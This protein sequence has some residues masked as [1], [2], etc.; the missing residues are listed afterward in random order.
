MQVY[1]AFYK[2]I[3][4][5]MTQIL[6]YIIVFVSIATSLGNINAKKEKSIFQETKVNIAFINDDKESEFIKGFEGY[7][8]R[9]CNI[10]KLSKEKESLQDALFYREVEYIIKVPKGF[11]E[12]FFSG[13]PV[14]I[15]T[16][17]V[18]ESSSEVYM[19]NM[20][21]KYLNTAKIYIN[22]IPNLS[23]EQ[24]VS[25]IDKD[26]SQKTEVKLNNFSEEVDKNKKIGFYYN[27]MAYSILGVLIL[28][29]CSVML[30]FNNRNL[31][32]RNLCTPVKLKNINFQLILGSLSFTVLAWLVM[33]IIS[34]FMYGSYMLTGKGLLLLLNSFIF[35]LASVS[36]GFLVGNIVKSKNTMS[37]ASNVIVLGTCFI[38]GVFVEQSLLSK[39]VLKLA[40]F[41]PNY[42]YVKANNGIVA[43]SGYSLESL[44]SIFLN[45]L[46]VMGFAVSILLV[47][48]VIIKQKRLSN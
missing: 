34:F 10:V 36:I 12:E 16:T 39:Q 44:S 48:L 21:N 5:N 43:L 20:V 23:F 19:D 14:A 29:I 3:L 35:S 13:K 31:K 8:N 30:V 26:L 37:V 18:P 22:N 45:M 2:V 32:I 42:W 17:A 27:Y 1:K 6:I 40:S 15:E 41:T 28:G 4:K 47:T 7:L 46:V 33:I 38:S 24:L 9:N 11:T 25:Y